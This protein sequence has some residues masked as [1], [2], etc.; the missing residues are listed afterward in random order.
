MINMTNKKLSNNLKR[1]DTRKTIKLDPTNRDILRYAKDVTGK[2][3]N[4]F[5][6]E[7]LN[8]WILCASAYKNF[9]YTLNVRSPESI[10][11]KFYGNSKLVSGSFKV[12]SEKQIEEFENDLIKNVAKIESNKLISKKPI[13]RTVK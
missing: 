1:K 7:Y 9:A 11:I 10:E 13:K 5:L 3:Y 12:T 2:D 4:E 6:N 8:A